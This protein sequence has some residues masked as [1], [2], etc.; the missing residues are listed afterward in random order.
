MK[1]LFLL[2]A[3]IFVAFVNISFA[4]T[5][6]EFGVPIQAEF[7]RADAVFIGKAVKVEDL[8]GKDDYPD[9][10]LKV[11]FKVLQNFKGAENTT[12]TIITNDWRAA[13]GLQI[14]KGQTWI[15][16]ASYNEEDRIFRSNI[17]NK[18]NFSE[19]KEELEILKLASE[20]KTDT[21]ISGRLTLSGLY[22]YEE[23]VEITVEGNGIQQTTTTK[24][25][26]T[27]S[28]ASLT[29]GSY[30]VKIKF[31]SGASVIYFTVSGQKP[32]FTKQM[33]TLFEYEVKLEQGDYDYSFFEISRYSK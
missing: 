3:L 15:I 23:A 13:C 28:V 25:D 9:N 32:E 30:K 21:T 22:P 31:L 6:F 19:D 8:T 26:G 2:L 12:F 10:W 11:Q 33:S 17:G 29:A 16:Y 14:K 1:N 5:R 24:S 20:R 7:T 18:Y 4:C 27:F